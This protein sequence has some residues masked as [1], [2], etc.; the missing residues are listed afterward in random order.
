M[1]EIKST[2]TDTPIKEENLGSV[3]S[4]SVTPS[5]EQPTKPVKIKCESNTSCDNTLPWGK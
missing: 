3:E 1:S 4:R 2:A 5:T